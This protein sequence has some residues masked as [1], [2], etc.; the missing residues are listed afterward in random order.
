[1]A[2][3]RAHDGVCKLREAGCAR[4]GKMWGMHAGAD[5]RDTRSGEMAGWWRAV[6]GGMAG[7]AFIIVKTVKARWTHMRRRTKNGLY[8]RRTCGRESGIKRSRSPL[9]SS[10]DAVGRFADGGWAAGDKKR[11][12]KSGVVR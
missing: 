12:D 3:G 9:Q 6:E 8:L 2:G 5:G 11:S 10:L 7:G 1:M 4:D